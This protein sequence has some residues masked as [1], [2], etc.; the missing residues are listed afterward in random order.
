MQ[1]LLKTSGRDRSAHS[2][3]GA[4]SRRLLGNMALGGLVSAS[5]LFTSS[6]MFGAMTTIELCPLVAK[7]TL[8][9]AVDT[10]KTISVVLALPS[11]DP[12][13]L[14]AFVDHVSTPGDPL[15]RQFITPQEFATRFGANASDYEFLKTWAGS[16]NLT[17]SQE[18]VGR[19]ILTVR[20]S[21]ATL[22]RLFKTEINNYKTS[23]GTV[24]Y[25]AGVKPTIP[26]EIGSKVVAVVG[27]TSGAPN[28]ALAKVGKALGEHPAANSALKPPGVTNALGTGPGGTYAPQDLQTAYS[29]PTN[30]GGLEKGQTL[31]IFEQGTYN[32][33]RCQFLRIVFQDR[34]KP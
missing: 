8:V 14:K 6:A 22:N 34:V 10:S 16:N 28:A 25:S 20:G 21:V 27:L 26:A 7:S 18:S 15:Y 31:G 4:G 23:D 32:H 11:S 1:G 29:I 2:I 19:T 13:G 3:G 12:A 9:S 5:L 24:F 30:F 17:I 33:G